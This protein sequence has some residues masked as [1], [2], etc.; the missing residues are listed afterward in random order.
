MK[1]VTLVALIFC[2]TITMAQS[3]WKKID[4]ENFAF[5][6][7]KV[8]R[9]TQPKK[10]SVYNLDL[11]SFKSELTSQ[12]KGISKIISLPGYNGKLNDY[13]VIETSNFTEPIHPK[14]GFIKS[15]SVQG[16]SDRSENG[17]ITVGSDGVHITIHSGNHPTVYV[18]PYSKDKTTYISYNRAN[19]EK[20]DDDF[21]CYVKE[22]V[23]AQKTEINT[24]QKTADDGFLRT[25]RLA[26][27]CTGEY[28]QYHINQQGVGGGT[29]TA[30]RAAVLSAMNTTMARVNGL[31]ERDL[32][33]RMNIILQSGD[34]PLIF[35]DPD[36][37]N[38]TNDSAGSLLTESQSTCDAVI[39]NANYDIGHAFS[40][41]AG[42]LAGLG[43]V[44]FA[45]KGRGVTGTSDPIGD[46][47]NVDYVA[48]EIGHQFGAPHTFN[49]SCDGNRSASSAVEPG[50][51]STIM[52]YAGIC[53][54]NVQNNS[55]D[56]FH[57]VSITSMWNHIQ[58]TFCGTTTAT[59]N[60]APVA[61]AGADFS[62]P[63]GTPLILRGN[64]TDADGTN[65][66]TYNWEQIDTEIATM[67]PTNGNTGGPQFR[68][69][70]SSSS[71]DR[72]LPKIETVAGGS[73]FSTWEVIPQVAREMNF[74]LV[75]RDNN[76]GGG[77]ADRD[78]MKVT[79]TSA[80]P[81]TVSNPSNTNWTGE[82]SQTITWDR[83]TT[84]Q[85]PINCQNVRIKL[86][87]DG[88]LTFPTTLIESTPND[89][90]QS[91][92]IPNIPTTTARIMVEAA[93]NIFYNMNS[94][95]F[96]IIDNPTASV[97]DFD[98]NNFSVYPNPS[99][100]NFN[101]TFEVINTE[102]VDI[103]LFD[104]RGRMIEQKEFNNTQS[105]FSEELNFD[106]ITT[107]LYLL[108]VQNGDKRTTRKLI[109]K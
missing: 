91:V 89:G 66:L 98:F 85:A 78:D 30:Q 33:V 70:S 99:N 50:S 97:D 21:T 96:N 90:S 18:D 94:V 105:T 53:E 101:I 102:S 69:F 75:V 72:Y 10:F 9:K 63:R 13:T 36:T 61:N 29:E 54:P 4:S 86:S 43:V 82:T 73:T 42:G 11:E 5:R 23:K 51:G 77:A 1:R 64:A 28:A 31:F 108:Q 56:H 87:T 41:G 84:H 39:G 79:V 100:G 62:V 68:S 6:G 40:T 83:S 25:Y 88:G 58:G 35:L 27:I 59:G 44:C 81:F 16:I 34:N 8:F 109:I 38:L 47:Y 92:T 37:D 24:A 45:Q 67:P 22:T 103:K 12:S 48:H 93:D 80:N 95:N 46:P 26:L 19:I 107:G 20:N 32:S 55:D 106:G 2:A 14:F 15:Y 71:P 3:S 104:I 76:A 74:S 17:K 52:A 65:S 60:N 49:N 57:S 7:E